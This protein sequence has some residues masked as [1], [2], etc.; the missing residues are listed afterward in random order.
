MDRTILLMTS[1]GA[2]LGHLTRAMAVARRLSS[3]IKPVVFTLSQGA[4]IAE[5]LGFFVEYLAPAEALAGGGGLVKRTRWNAL[6][7][8]RLLE[9][10]DLY[11]P[12]VVVFDGTH[13]YNGL[14]TAIARSTER[15]WVWCRRGMWRPGLGRSSL[16]RSR[17]FDSIVQPRDLAA[18]LDGGLTTRLQDDVITV[19]PIFLLDDDELPGRAS[20]S[21]SL[22]LDES[23]LC[24]FV[25]LGAGNINDVT[26][27]V[28]RCVRGLLKD[29]RVEV[30]LAESPISE[31][32]MTS[33]KELTRVRDYPAT[34]YARRFDLAV[35]AAG[36]NTFHE[37]IRY[38]VPTLF[39]PNNRTKLDDQAARAR[40]AGSRD[41]GLFWEETDLSSLSSKIEELLDDA[42]RAEIRRVLSE[43]DI[44]NGAADLARHLSRL[45]GAERL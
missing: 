26:S 40:Y 5:E 33:W 14:I 19:P 6:L 23:R 11:E 30:V 21:A 16:A 25:Q 24:A 22:G 38:G 12:S 1:N 2:G 28:H 32:R 34:R 31:R 8:D 13:P 35:C 10:L 7:R 39:I 17:F 18:K 45:A 20:A 15:H 43:L 41:L 27:M 3:P 4:P 44:S 42:R 29:S 9:L 37:L 36:Y